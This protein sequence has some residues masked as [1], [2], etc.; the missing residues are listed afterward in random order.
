MM[1]L[2][3]AAL[4]FVF[5]WLA[6]RSRVTGVYLS[7]MTQALSYALMLAFFRNDMG[8]GGNNGFTD[9]KDILGFDLQ[10]DATR[11]VLLVTHGRGAGRELLGV[12]RHRRVARR[13]GDPRDPRRREPDAVPRLPRRVLQAVGVRV[14]GGRGRRRRARCTSRRS[15]SSTRASSRR[16][17]RSKSSSGWRS[18]GAARSTAPPRARCSSTTRRRSSPARCPKSGSTRSATLF[19]LVTLFLPRGIMGLVP[20]R[21]GG[22][23]NAAPA[24]RGSRPP[25]RAGRWRE[26]REAAARRAPPQLPARSSISSASPSASTASRRSTGSRSTSTRASCAAS[27]ARTAPA[28]RR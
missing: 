19:V 10:Q 27:S 20:A 16:S 2:V 15:A 11:V 14:L 26:M 21:R 4:A 17:T 24:E 9:F 8:F 25:A 13:A 6:F 3:P 28:R 23:M 18:A 22:E 5:G 12:P 1:V 7:I